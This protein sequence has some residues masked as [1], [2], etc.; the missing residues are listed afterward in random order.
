MTRREEHVRQ[1]RIIFELLYRKYRICI[2]D[3]AKNLKVYPSTASRRLKES[4]SLGHVTGPQIRKRSHSNTKEYVYFIKCD[5][6][7]RLYKEYINNMNITYHAEMIGFADLWVIS[8]KKI[9]IDGDVIAEGFRSDYHYS[10]P[11]DHSWE[12]TA[13]LMKEKI[14]NFNPENY[15][16]QGIIKTLWNRSIKWDPEYEILYRE[17]KYNFRSKI[18][19]IMKKHHISGEK[20]YEWI[21]KISDYC[22]VSI[23]YFPET[24]SAYDAYLFMVDTEY[25]D[26]I[27][28]LFS[29]LPTTSFFFKV[30]NKLFMYLHAA[31]YF[32]RS[33]DRQTA[34]KTMC[35]PLL[36]EELSERRILKS[37]AVSVIQFSWGKE[38]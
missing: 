24:L 27:I 12:T 9:K 26:F 22:T 20:I 2:K 6:P 18:T 8:N 16:A 11:P 19:P 17:F 10:F 7:A 3:I 23:S 1:Y 33:H 4:F 35:I 29:E 5:N 36:V 38:L 32:V 37:K 31:R 28:D 30:S 25:E 13:R 34:L 15:K 21:G 14:E